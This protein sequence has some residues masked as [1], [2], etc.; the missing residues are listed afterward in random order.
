VAQ[1]I[2]REAVALIAGSLKLLR[3]EGW[4][5]GGYASRESSFPVLGRFRQD[6]RAREIARGLRLAVEERAEPWRWHH[7]SRLIF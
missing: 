3:K 1:L 4:M 6:G 2:V 7:G 5:N